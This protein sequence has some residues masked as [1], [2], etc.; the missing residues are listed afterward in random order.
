VQADY[1]F[2]KYLESPKVK[3]LN[4]ALN[5]KNL[6]NLKLHGLHY[7]AA[8]IVFG[9]LVKSADLPFFVV[10]V[11]DREKAAYFY[12][13]L[14]SVIENKES[15]FFLP[16][17]FKR[18]YD[19]ADKE[20]TDLLLR[21]EVLSNIASIKK[22]AILVTYP[23]ALLETVVSKKS[24]TE[25]SLTLSIGEKVSVSFLEELLFSYQFE[26]TDFV[27]EPGQ[28][29]V[30]GG[31]VDV[32]S[33][34]YDKPFRIEF[35]GSEVESI[36]PFNPVDQLSTGKARIVTLLPNL[37]KNKA[38]NELRESI[39]DFLPP[40]TIF[41]FESLSLTQG[42]SELLSENAEK[43]FDRVKKLPTKH[44]PP[45][46]LIVFPSLLN[47]KLA[48]CNKVI[49][50]GIESVLASDF[51]LRFNLKS[52]PKFNKNFNLLA[53]NLKDNK[54]KNFENF[55]AATSPKQ[56]E[57]LYSV[58]EDNDEKPEFT[59]LLFEINEGFV[60]EDLKLAVYTDHQLFER[61]HRFRL[62]EGFKK[63]QQAL[64]I[65]ELSSLQPG[66]FVTHVDHGIGKFSGMEKIMVGGK[67]QEAVR[68]VYK[69]NDILYVSIH[70][71]HR[72][73]K[74]TGK[75]G[76]APKMYKLGGAAWQNLK[77][78]TKAKVKEVA[79]DLI[80]LYAKRREQ[81]GFQFNPDNYL[82][83]ELEASFEYEETPDQLKAVNDVKYDMEREMPMD[84]LVCGDVGFGK[85]EVAIRAAF[86]AVCDNKQVAIL[87]PTTVLSL[88][89]YK[90]FKK[91]LADFPVN[92]DYVNRFK[93]TKNIK[94]TLKNVAE[95]KVDILI[96]THRLVSKD[97]KFKDLGLL[98][99]DEEQK[100]G[101]SV[102]D[103]LKTF[104]VNVD[105]LTLTA[106]PIP[107]T[108]Q[109]SL[110]SAR[111]M[112]IINTPP[113]NRYPVETKLVGFNQ[114]MIK[115]AIAYELSRDG[116]VFF[117][118]NK[119]HNLHEISN[120]ITS[121][122]PGA[123]VAV[124]HG[125]MDGNQL[126]DIMAGFYEGNYDVLVATTI[127]ES[128]IDV[129][130]ANTIIINEA[131]NFGLSDLHQLRGRVGRS[132]KKAFCYLIAPPLQHV[133]TES[134]KRLEALVQFSDLGSGFNIA[135][136]DLDIRGAGDL[137]GA[138]QSGFISD[139]GF[140]M[141][142]KILDEAV[143]ELKD[144]EFKDLFED[145]NDQKEKEIYRGEC[146]IETDLSLLYPDEYIV[147]ITERLALYK[148]LTEVNNLE[149]LEQ[150]R[151]NLVDRFGEL[152]NEA[153]EL[154]NS[155]RLKWLGKQLGMEKIIIKSEKMICSFV[156][157]QDN[158]FFQSSTFTSILQFVQVNHK[159][160]KMYQKNEALRLSIS[161]IGSIY[162]AINVLKPIT[163]QPEKV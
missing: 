6:Q 135:M 90:S 138:D 160:T 159:K 92:I 142:Q 108:L 85:T 34:A 110:M 9:S 119:I 44:Q 19:D 22:N 128:G 47:Q 137:L 98:I 93:S 106:T 121:L 104:R 75:E 3:Q 88:Q 82:M 162:D 1:I 116:Q 54:D 73:S 2:K 61:Y 94:E 74:Y 56:V 42:K 150:Y 149:E 14:E 87:V 115:E 57:R 130:N 65:K 146:V 89:H 161:N 77:R 157:D 30:R 72:I 153:E 48:G 156:E 91:R 8:S 147:D 5:D 7:S 80:K 13:D 163:L 109:F 155:V 140:E 158:P 152:P 139:I 125:Q 21:S 40:S 53:Q 29:A 10:V 131:H 55:I 33:Y 113:P 62:K 76:T 41:A 86:K 60:D 16:S 24:I 43:E 136:R 81:K 117:V 12:N 27:I 37:E 154:L 97:V 95:G 66:D 103:K 151:L 124:G 58:F 26:K 114:Q 84:R 28:F 49:E 39:F 127:I 59:P 83:H 69:D 126:E 78:K 11:S 68:L 102:K 133:S 51:E 25:K 144:A 70:S 107:R 105:T 63:N 4:I 122:V 141:Y 129:S 79:F 31:I 46:Q 32:F 20:N 111:D 64:T 71:L 35:F 17:A 18:F 145:R 100:F 132:N 101:V 112:S 52:Q 120:L 123:R 15:V 38:E 96:G 143:Q 148:A 134:R 23:E 99:I 50:F 67:Y 45:E 36:R 118:N